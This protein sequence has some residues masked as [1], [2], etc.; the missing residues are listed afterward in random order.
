MK[1]RICKQ[2]GNDEIR[3]MNY[4]RCLRCGAQTQTVNDSPRGKIADSP[5]R[6]RRKLFKT[7]S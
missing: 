1:Q 5:R 4:N 6:G 7:A 3:Q 2:C